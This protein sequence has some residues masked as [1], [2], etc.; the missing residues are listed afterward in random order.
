MLWY[1]APLLSREERIDVPSRLRNMLVL[2]LAIPLV[3]ATLHVLTLVGV[4]LA[5]TIVCGLRAYIA[6]GTTTAFDPWEGLAAAVTLIVASPYIPRAPTDGDSLAYHLPNALAWV[7]AHSLDPTWMR[8]WWYPPGSELSISGVVAAGGLWITGAVSLLAAVMLSTRLVLWLRTLDVPAPAAV[9]LSAAFITISTVAFQ[10]YDQR[11]D[12]ILA[13]WFLEALWMLRTPDWTGIIPIVALSL[14]KPYGWAYALL[15]TVCMSRPRLLVGLVPILLWSLHDALLAPHAINSVESTYSSGAWST[16]ILGNLPSSL[17]VLALAVG[18]R[19][20]A[21]VVF[22][23]APLFALFMPGEVRRLA[24]IGIVSI[25]FFL[26]SPFGYGNNLPQL[27]FGWSL[28][29]DLPALVLGVLCVAPIARRIPIVVIALSILSAVAGFA[30]L[31]YILNHDPTIL[32]AVSFACIAGIAACLAFSPQLRRVSAPLASVASLALFLYGSGVASAN[33]V[34]FYGDSHSVYA[35]FRA[36]P[37]DA[38]SVNLRAGTLLMLAPAVRIIDADGIDCE[39]AQ[40]EKAWIVVA[41]GDERAQ[42]ARGCGRVLFED[43]D[44][45][46]VSPR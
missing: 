14:M 27:A 10:T 12:L 1:A 37:H 34:S 46:A 23:L 3:L 44:V 32:A 17:A 31:L 33:V 36:H 7:Q 16:T 40:I 13:A 35:W 43:A 19:G 21:M 26:L 38:E 6:R 22:F 11:N 39:G 30:R 8:Y 20:P 2:L 24:F 25:V 18:A 15:A 42:D 9:A 29:F 41:K 4:F 28:R 5:A 45:I